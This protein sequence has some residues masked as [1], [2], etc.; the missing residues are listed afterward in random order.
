MCIKRVMGE[1]YGKDDYEEV[2]IG[3]NHQPNFS[4]QQ[5]KVL[6]ETTMLG[7]EIRWHGEITRIRSLPASKKGAQLSEKSFRFVSQM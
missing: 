7:G 6:C 5:K 2:I 4:E 1:L 3:V